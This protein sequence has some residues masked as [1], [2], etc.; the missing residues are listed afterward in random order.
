MIEEVIFEE[1]EDL[2]ESEKTSIAEEDPANLSSYAM[3]L[4]RSRSAPLS[5]PDEMSPVL[6]TGRRITEDEMT[7]ATTS[8]ASSIAGPDVGQLV[9]I[10][11]QLS[12]QP[13]NKEDILS[14]ERETGVINQR[15]VSSFDQEFPIVDDTDEEEEDD[16]D[17]DVITNYLPQGSN[18]EVFV[19]NS[20]VIEAFPKAALLHEE[21]EVD[22]AASVSPDSQNFS[23]RSSERRLTTAT[24]VASTNSASKSEEIFSKNEE[25]VA[26]T[27]SMG[28]EDCN[29]AL[30]KLRLS[31]EQDAIS[32]ESGYSEESTVNNQ[33]NENKSRLLNA[34]NDSSAVKRG[35]L[36][37]GKTTLVTLNTTLERNKNRK[38][39]EDKA[40]DLTVHSAIISDFSSSERL[41]YLDRS[42][43]QDQ[44]FLQNKITEFCI[45]I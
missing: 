13:M 20:A 35:D 11:D 9:D 34:I 26:D 19:S 5:Q 42:R 4:C 40:E 3:A 17:N 23:T 28:E 24:A 2:P 16:D 6:D 22:S 45:N 12:F 41:K 25:T 14:R 10:D 8:L 29:E 18:N 15:L 33:M 32:D 21:V 37:S 7:T 30:G 44:D 1:E 43:A 38:V 39:D 31:S 27:D 36:V